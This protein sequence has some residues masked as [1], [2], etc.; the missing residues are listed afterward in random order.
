MWAIVHFPS[1]QIQKVYWY[2]ITWNS[3]PES[4]TTKVKCQC[5]KYLVLY[6]FLDMVA[7]YRSTQITKC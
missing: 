5:A 1:Q 4:F 6:N 3:Y 2:N 7:V